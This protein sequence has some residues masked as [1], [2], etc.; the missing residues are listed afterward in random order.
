MPTQGT[1]GVRDCDRAGLPLSRGVRSP[2]GLGPGDRRS[3]PGA[4]LQCGRGLPDQPSAERRRRLSVVG[5][6][7]A[8]AT[9]TGAEAA[10]AGPRGDRF[11]A[12]PTAHRRARPSARRPAAPPAGAGAE[13]T[14]GGRKPCAR[15]GGAGAGAAGR[16]RAFGQRRTAQAGRPGQGSG[17]R[18]PFAPLDA[19]GDRRRGGRL[20]RLPD[21]GVPGALDL[22]AACEDL[23][24]LALELGFSSHSHFG[25]AF[26]QTYGR[27]PSEFRQDALAG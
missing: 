10:E 1:G 15:A 3:E 6:R 14:A 26:R 21:P 23:T 27:S 13:R 9:G 2:P 17:G 20:A 12:A 8:P 7:R 5:H 19:V 25:A 18:R 22:L 4:V 11:R 16:R 24:A